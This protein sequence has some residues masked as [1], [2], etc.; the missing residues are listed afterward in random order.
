LRAERVA[1][2]RA[3]VVD[4]DDNGCASV[5]KLV[6]ARVGFASQLPAG[7]ASWAGTS[8]GTD[9]EEILADGGTEAGLGEEA[10]CCG[11]GVAVR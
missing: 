2:G 9:T 11:I 3:Q 10:A 1:L 4:H 5:G 7:A 6:A 8:T